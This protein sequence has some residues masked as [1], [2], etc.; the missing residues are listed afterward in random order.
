MKGRGGERVEGGERAVRFKAALLAALLFCT[1]SS[2][3]S[4]LL[5]YVCISNPFVYSLY[6]IHEDDSSEYCMG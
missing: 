3:S 2:I 6:I 1:K 5:I 4:D